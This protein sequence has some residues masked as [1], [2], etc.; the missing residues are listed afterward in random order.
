MLDLMF[1]FAMFSPA[2]LLGLKLAVLAILADTLIGWILALAKGGFDI[3]EVPRFLQT[4]IFPYIGVL[5]V[6]ALVTVADSSYEPVFFFICT[7]ITAKFGVEA[8]KDKL[9]QFFK[10]A[11]EPPS[12][13]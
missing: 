9:T 6:L 1:F 5:L 13:G 8:L 2:V 3:R 12:V 4:S 7:I 11:N 10:P